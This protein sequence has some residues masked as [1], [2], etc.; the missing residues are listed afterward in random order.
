MLRR[1]AGIV[2]P[3]F[4]LRTGHDLGRG[5]IGGLGPMLDWA[6]AM[7]HRL[8]Q[9]LPLNETTPGEASPYSALSVFAI[10]PMYIAVEQIEGIPEAA[11]KRAYAEIGGRR[12]VAR[13][14]VRSKKLD[15]LE[16]AFRWFCAAGGGEERAAFAQFQDANQYWLSAYALFRAL[17]DR[18]N[19]RAW[20]EWPIALRE[21]DR[22]AIEQA[23]AELADSIAKYSYWQF[24][25]HRQIHAARASYHAAGAMIGGDLA[26][27]PGRDSAEV[28]SRQDHFDLSRLAGAPPDAFSASGQRWGLPMPRWDRMAAEGWPLVRSRMRQARELYDVVRIDHVVGLYRTYSFAADSDDL[29][30]FTPA[31]VTA[32]REQ[33]E[34][35]IRAIQSEAPDTELIAEDLGLIPDWVHESLRN[36]KVPGYKV[37]RWE[38]AG[39][40]NA[41]D[42]YL[43]PACYS[44]LSV[45]TTGT[46][47][48][49]TL[50]Q[51]WRECGAQQ[52]R[53]LIESMGLEARGVRERA[54]LDKVTLDALLE[55]L[56]ASPSVVVVEPLQDLFGWTAR[57]NY[58]GTVR[59]SN[60]SWRLPA[61]I[62]HLKTSP[63]IARHA[64]VLAGIAKR[65]GR[66]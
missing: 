16:Q 30:Y 32:Q 60:W 35:I 53:L 52:R 24:L 23:R 43:D 66:F 39:H 37:L 63:V 64:A 13:E 18:F 3:L 15:L 1:S 31:E 5:D 8:I 41:E 58:P 34:S 12:N 21:L 22:S 29:G 14:V 28:W 40:G 10:D 2:I 48:T 57:I 49:E 59:A 46:H 62:E 47:D 65:T 54:I 27:S 44:E 4:S 45:A 36:L 20:D 38:K 55:A 50:A 42:R 61:T 6:L 25:A 11:L 9:L 19:W 17:K 7:G 33:G 51:W 26:F 56:Y